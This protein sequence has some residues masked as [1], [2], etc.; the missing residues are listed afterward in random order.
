[1]S[2]HPVEDSNRSDNPQFSSIVESL[3]SRRGLLRGSASAVALGAASGLLLSGCSDDGGEPRRLGFAPVAKSLEDRVALPAG[4]SA[5]VLYALGDPLAAGLAEYANDGSDDGNWDRR[6]GDHH[7]GMAYFPFPKGSGSATEGLLAVNHEAL[8]DIYLHANGPT[9][10]QGRRPLAEVVKEQHAHGVSVIKIA[11]SANGWAVDRGAAQN[12]RWHVNSPMQISGPVA[13]SPLLVTKLSPDATTTHGTLN[14]C[15]H[16]VTPWGSF[17]TGEENW[18]AYFTV[19]AASDTPELARY[20]IKSSA[21]GFNYRGWDTP[22]MAGDLQKRF[23]LAQTGASAATDFRNA[24]HHFG[25]VVEIDPYDPTATPKKRTALGRFSHE[26]AW[27]APAVAGKPLAVYMGDDARNEYIYKF[28]SAAN[29][30]PADANGGLAAG[31]KYLDAGTLYVA[32][33]DEDG[34]GTWIPLTTSNPALAAFSA[35]EILIHTRKAADAAGGTKMDRPEWGTV[36]PL[37]GEV[38]VTLTNS[39]S[40]SSGRGQGGGSSQPLDAANP[41]CYDADTGSLTD[42]VNG[43]VN[44]HIIRWREANGSVAATRFRWDIYLFGSRASYPANVNVSRLTDDN[45]F[46]SP[47]GL[48]CDARGVLWIQT[49]DGA[50]TRPTANDPKATN[51]MMLAALPGSVGDGATVTIGTQKTYVGALPRSETLARFLVG[52]PGCEITGVD[53]TPDYRTMF[54]NIQ[55]PG[56]N[57]SLTDFES[58]WPNAS[59]NALDLGTPGVRP[60]SATIVITRDDGGEI[61]L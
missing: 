40:S 18:F 44:G 51:C 24:A 39:S 12:K 26:G 46:S 43:N 27:F 53:L 56:E 23:N 59:R 9:S 17:L 31:D 2:H 32:R 41:R 42:S 19:D 28:V 16:G 11:K 61:G 10:I 20:G 21:P 54:V 45:D 47:D 22:L 35:D 5:R 3:I 58:N 48:W 38:Y 4:Y 1:M 49:D 14:N 29:W 25:Y 50:Y 13:G 57:G 34:S 15:G 37:T 8:T 52:V 55:H 6:A 33:F 7:D 36:H 60:R 30:D